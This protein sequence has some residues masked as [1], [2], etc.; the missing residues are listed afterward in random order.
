MSSGRCASAASVIGT[1]RT[2]HASRKAGD[3]YSSPAAFRRPALEISQATPNAAN[4]SAVSSYSRCGTPPGGRSP[5]TFG[6]SGCAITSY[7]PEPAA[8]RSSSKYSRHTSAT[9]YA[10]QTG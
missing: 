10:C 8:A 5:K 2:A 9:E 3:G 6:R 7:R 1:S 4:A